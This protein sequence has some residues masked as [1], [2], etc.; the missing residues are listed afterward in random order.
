MTMDIL[1]KFYKIRSWY[2]KYDQ[3]IRKREGKPFFRTSHGLWGA[4]GL[5]DMFEFFTKI[6]AEK[7]TFAD[8]GSGDG[9]IVLIAA[10]FTQATGIEGQEDLTHIA[11]KAKK[12]LIKDIP[13]LDRATFKTGNYYEESHNDYDILFFF[14]DHAFPEA[15]QEKLKEI[16]SGH[17]IIYTKIHSPS[18][19]KKGK[20]YWVQ[21]V[22][23]VSYPVNITE[24]NLFLAPLFDNQEK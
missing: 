15:F 20:T 23:I 11:Q 5:L 6:D 17:L 12:E 1:E 21:Q 7:F 9:R 8:Y 19:L 18:L 2:D 22:P 14:P 3:E 24:E 16:F 13:E 10:L 4:A